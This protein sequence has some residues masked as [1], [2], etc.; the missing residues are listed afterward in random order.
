MT[1]LLPISRFFLVAEIKCCCCFL[2]NCTTY[3][4]Q[5]HNTANTVLFS[6]NQN[7]DILYVNDINIINYLEKNKY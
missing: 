1:N 6:T 4:D 7:A 5:E 2:S 3:W